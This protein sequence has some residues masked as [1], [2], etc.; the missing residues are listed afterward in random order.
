MQME[1]KGRKLAAQSASDDAPNKK[2]ART[3]YV[4][5]PEDEDGGGDDDMGGKEEAHGNKDKEDKLDKLENMMRKM[6]TMMSD[7][8]GDM[9]KVTVVV[10]SA[11][12]IAK[13]AK[14]QSD[15]IKGGRKRGGHT[16]G[17][18]NH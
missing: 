13:E 17:N 6:M 12:A 18:H 2:E 10:A 14:M 1:G 9:S 4:L 16:P 7:M 15:S 3:G 5:V 8:K 11:T